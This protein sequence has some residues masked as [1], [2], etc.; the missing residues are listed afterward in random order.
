MTALVQKTG[1]R[2]TADDYRGEVW[3]DGLKRRF[4]GRNNGTIIL[5]HRQAADALNVHRNTG[6]EELEARGLHLDG[7]RPAPWPLGHRAGVRLGACG[8]DDAGHEARTEDLHGVALRHAIPS[9]APCISFPCRRLHPGTPRNR[10]ELAR[11]R[12]GP[13]LR[14]LTE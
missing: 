8:G 6:F 5:S 1:H 2:E 13:E 11:F 14:S 7:A 3:R 12:S 9:A 10:A 4:N